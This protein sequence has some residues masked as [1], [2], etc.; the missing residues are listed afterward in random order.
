MRRTTTLCSPVGAT[1]EAGTLTIERDTFNEVVNYAKAAAPQEVCGFLLVQRTDA[2]TYH[3]LKDSLLI[4]A[5]LIASGYS[6]VLPEGEIEQM[7]FEEAYEDDPTVFRLLWHSHVNG[8]AQFSGTDTDTH[9]RMATTTAHEAMFFMVLNTHG[10]ATANIEVYQ[11]FRIGTQLRLVVLE[12]DEQAALDPYKAML[13]QKCKQ[14]PKPKHKP[15]VQGR[16]AV[17]G[18]S[19]PALLGQYDDD[20]EGSDS[21]TVSPQASGLWNSQES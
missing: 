15:V 20:T 17:I 10:Q 11:P 18:S 5:Q 13:K 3:V 16:P 6:E 12:N 14:M 21:I 19:L 8:I 9:R 4:P 1:T 7:D 2:A